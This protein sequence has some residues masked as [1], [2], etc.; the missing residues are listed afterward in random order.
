MN[1]KNLED[2][3]YFRYSHKINIIEKEPDYSS[4]YAKEEF[5]L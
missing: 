2:I 5:I 3:D 1:G 4:N